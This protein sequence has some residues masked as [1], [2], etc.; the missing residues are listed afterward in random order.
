MRPAALGSRTVT[1]SA[2]VRPAV[3]FGWMLGILASAA[4]LAPA[5]ICRAVPSF[6]RQ[7]NMQCIACHTEFPVLNDMGRQFKLSGYTMSTGQTDLPP[8]AVMLQPSFTATRAGQDGGAAPSFAKNNNFA[9]SQASIFYAGRLV[10]PYASTWF[11]E[12]TAAVL[13]K[14]GIFSQTTYDGVAKKWA[15]DNTELRFADATAID[16]HP[17]SY[18][19]YINN[20]PTLQDPWNSTPAWGFPLSSS[21]LATTPAAATLINGGLSGQVAGLGA[22]TMIDNHFYFDVGAYQTL[23]SDFQ[24][25]VGIDPA[26]E[27]QVTGLAPYWRFAYTQPLAGG[28]WEVGTFGLAAATYPGRDSSSGKDHITDIGLDTQFQKSFGRSDI[29]TTASVIF[30]HSQ[31]D[32]SQNLGNTDNASDSLREYKLT[33]NYL[34]DKTYGLTAQYFATTGTSDAAA[35]STSTT[36]SPNSNGYVLQANYLP[37]NKGTGPAFW[38]RSNVKFSIQYVIYNQFDGSTH[39]VDGNGRSAHDND[40]LYLE[41]WIVF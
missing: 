27:T 6:A 32:A 25:S 36:G 33:E 30:E 18:G 15:W 38:P 28:S 39:N 12:D 26:G 8:L 40:T 24:K 17:A 10:G 22:Y 11:S 19:V 34:W 23:S 2:G 21:K 37:F 4:F 35:Y 5:T 7:M 1:M 20:N 9:L 16:G 29:T 3:R 13:N 31:W 14:I 41:A